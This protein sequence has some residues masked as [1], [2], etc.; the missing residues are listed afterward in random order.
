M[1][2]W[3]P[4]TASVGPYIVQ[5]SVLDSETFFYSLE[6]E[7]HQMVKGGPEYKRPIVS[8]KVS[9]ALLL[10]ADISRQMKV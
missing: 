1:G 6:L 5:I 2:S 3:K 7:I 9:S 10:S 8:K 4:V